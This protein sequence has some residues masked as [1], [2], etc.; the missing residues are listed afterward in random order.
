MTPHQKHPPEQ[1]ATEENSEKQKNLMTEL[2]HAIDGEHKEN[3]HLQE[4]C[5][6]DCKEYDL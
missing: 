3:R 1:A 5:L 6:K 2:S 4:N